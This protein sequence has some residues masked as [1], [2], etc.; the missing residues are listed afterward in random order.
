MKSKKPKEDKLT[1]PGI[2]K[3][4]LKDFDWLS[5]DEL[6]NKVN[7]VW[8]NKCDKK[9]NVRPDTFTT[10]INNL[11]AKKEIAI[12]KTL[13]SKNDFEYKPTEDKKV[14]F[15]KLISNFSYKLSPQININE[16]INE[17][18]NNY[19][20]LVFK[21]NDLTQIKNHF[22]DDLSFEIEAI[23]P[24]YTKSPAFLVDIYKCK[25]PNEAHSYFEKLS[26]PGIESSYV[27]KTM[28]FRQ[29]SMFP[30]KYER[31][32]LSFKTDFQYKHYLVSM[33]DSK[34][35]NQLFHMPITNDI[36]KTQFLVYNLVVVIYRPK[37]TLDYVFKFSENSKIFECIQKY[38]LSKIQ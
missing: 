22:I 10:A 18:K 38:I 11:L 28:D 19:T 17:L 34:Y 32:E 27:D 5:Y 16:L 26:K 35:I 9:E 33:D 29:Y 31:S 36:Y 13:V 21:N 8:W 6:Y 14:Y 1:C 37:D 7:D 24:K 25:S 4:V 20:D 12:K 15:F 23:N 3:L 30:A 2:I